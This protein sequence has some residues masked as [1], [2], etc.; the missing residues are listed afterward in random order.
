M[1]LLVE[2]WN[3]I[4]EFCNRV[5]AFQKLDTTSRTGRRSRQNVNSN[6]DGEEEKEYCS[7]QNQTQQGNAVAQPFHN[8]LQ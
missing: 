8:I 2:S 3:S 5:F 7:V 1:L 4:G 6:V